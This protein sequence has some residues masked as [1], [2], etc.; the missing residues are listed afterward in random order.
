MEDF[1]LEIA[2]Q[3]IDVVKDIFKDKGSY[4]VT[5][6][7]VRFIETIDWKDVNLKSMKNYVLKAFPTSSLPE[8]P[9]AKLEHL[10]SGVT[11]R[12][13]LIQPLKAGA[14]L[15]RTEDLEMSDM[16]SSAAED[17]I[18]KTVEKL[19]YDKEWNEEIRAQM[20]TGIFS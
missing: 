15:M 14:R 13:E 20:A 2:S 16:L 10:H 12:Q 7:G 9:M 17:L 19:I 4:Q 11:C 3:M 6:P 18:C 1:Y 5:W 8:E